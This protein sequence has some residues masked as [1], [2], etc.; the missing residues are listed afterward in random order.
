MHHG[1]GDHGEAAARTVVTVA[2]GAPAVSR[3]IAGGETDL[4]ILCA[5]LGTVEREGWSRST[6]YMEFVNETQ[7]APPTAYENPHNQEV[8]AVTTD[9]MPDNRS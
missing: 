1:G 3:V 5:V 7:D 2:E 8:E 4:F 9:I 6:R